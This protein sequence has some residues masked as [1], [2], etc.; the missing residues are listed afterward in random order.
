MTPQQVSLAYIMR[1]NKVTSALFNTINPDHLRENVRAL[2][3]ELPQEIVDK[4]ERNI[5]S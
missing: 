2:D 5:G 1:N 4:I 3:M